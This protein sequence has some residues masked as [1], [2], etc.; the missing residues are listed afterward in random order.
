MVGQAPII[1]SLI[2][3]IF[4]NINQS[5]PFLMAV[6]AVWFGTNN[7]AREI[8]G[9]MPIFKRERMF[10][11]GI[12]PY[13]LSKI[14]VLSTFAALQSL[15]FTLILYIRYSSTEPSWNNPVGTFAWMLSLSIAATMMGLLLSAVVSTTDKVMTIV[16]IALIPQIMLAG[17][18]AKI[19]NQWVEML[20][21]VTLSRWGTEGF[22]IIQK[23]VS[24]EVPNP[25]NTKEV[26]LQVV[27]AIKQLK[28]SFHESYLTR[29][30]DWAY[31]LP[32]DQ[33]A[34]LIITCICFIGIYISL[35]T[36]DSIRIK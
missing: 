35:K 31:K 12:L 16:P 28:E 3:L 20:S 27:P 32:I 5:V 4:S 19:E 1:A 26:T 10:N 29:F 9:E 34:L 33:I 17:V 30:G 15:L 8:V 6:C 25:Q 24:V 2:C 11:Q 14:T 18:M 7:A 22:S 13:M 21:Y 23:N 36:K